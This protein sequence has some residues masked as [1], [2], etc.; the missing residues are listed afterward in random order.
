MKQRGLITVFLVSDPWHNLRIRRMATDLHVR[1]YVAATWSSA[2][3][4]RSTRLAGYTRETLAYL[5]YRLIGR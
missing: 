2:A 1:A 5:R 3:R 4:S